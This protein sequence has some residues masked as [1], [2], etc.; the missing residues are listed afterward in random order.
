MF[1][2]KKLFDY[3]IDF[4]IFQIELDIKEVIIY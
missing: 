3:F 2:F 1:Y 4:Q